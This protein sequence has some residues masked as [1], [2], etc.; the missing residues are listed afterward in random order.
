MRCRFLRYIIQNHLLEFLRIYYNSKRMQCIKCTLKFSDLN[1]LFKHIEEVHDK[2]GKDHFRCTLC[3]E[4]LKNLERFKKHARI[5][6]Q[7]NNDLD[8][9][10]H[11]KQAAFLEAYNDVEME[12]SNITIFRSQNQ[13]SALH[14][15]SKMSANMDTSRSLVFE[16]ISDVQIFLNG[17]IDGIICMILHSS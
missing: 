2:H 5:C 14:L 13:N 6:F 3:N 7:K 12:D 16:T 1:D 11:E 10:E 4:V 17:V 9:F 15:V 8:E